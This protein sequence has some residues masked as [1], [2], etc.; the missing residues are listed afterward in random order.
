[1]LYQPENLSLQRA[2]LDTVMYADIFD[3]PLTARE[4]QG[5]LIGASASL[6]SVET[7]LASGFLACS[8]GYYSLPGRESIVYTRLYREGI[9]A[10]M[11]LAARRYG[12]LIAGLPFVR[13]V[14]VTGSLSVN[15]VDANG[16]IDYLIVTQV[17]RL[18]LCR[19][20]VLFVVRLAAW[21]GVSLCPNYMVTQEALAFTD[22]NLYS[23]HE[24]IQMVPLYGREIYQQMVTANAWV[25]DFLPGMDE[26]T[27]AS[28]GTVRQEPASPLK[29]M[30]ETMLLTPPGGWFE[31]WEMRRKLR[32]LSIENAGNPEAV[33][34]PNLCKGHANRHG[35]RTQAAFTDRLARS[36][37]EVEK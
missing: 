26:L 22:R 11:W 24:F 3:Y 10:H 37:V 25:R 30:L 32:K 9:A 2:I 4:I 6:E 1:M 17:G 27:R 35:W 28:Q 33:F 13:M 34:S 19:L 29:T 12:K 14:A 8:D 31:G 21:R 36:V 15:N 18:W 20:L 7:C 16:D 23:A 5:Y